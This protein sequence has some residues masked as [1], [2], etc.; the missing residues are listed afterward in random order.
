[1]SLGFVFISLFQPVNLVVMGFIL[2]MH[3]LLQISALV[4]LLFPFCF[5]APLVL[6]MALVGHYGNVLDEIGPSG[7]DELPTPLRNVS[8]GEDIWRPFTQIALAMFLAFLPAL[9]CRD[10]TMP[11]GLAQLVMMICL[12]AGALAA[13]ALVLTTVTSGTYLNLRPDRIVGVIATCAARYWLTCLTFAAAMVT[14]WLALGIMNAGV[15]AFFR[16]KGFSAA[17]SISGTGYAVLAGAIYLM[18][19]FC[20]QLGLIYRTYHERFPWVLQRHIPVRMAERTRPTR[21][22]SG[23]LPPIKR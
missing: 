22:H 19:G 6:F 11:P 9:I 8:F 20:W 23:H 4:T 1:M 18:H 14:Y 12:A 3:L 17:A 2:L 21:P 7:R 16:S 15:L 10:V 5:L 13:P